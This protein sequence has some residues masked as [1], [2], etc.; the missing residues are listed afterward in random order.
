MIV[1]ILVHVTLKLTGRPLLEFMRDAG[2]GKGRDRDR[3]RTLTRRRE[4]EMPGGWDRGWGEQLFTVLQIGSNSGRS[5]DC[6]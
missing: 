1:I 5:M 2:S 4:R 3:Q 6:K